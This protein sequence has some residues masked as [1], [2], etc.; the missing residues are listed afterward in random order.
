MCLETKPITAFPLIKGKPYSYCRMC[1][2]S[3]SK[4]YRLKTKEHKK[5]VDRI[6]RSKPEV[7]ERRKGLNRTWRKCNA[8][9]VKTRRRAAKL[10]RLYGITESDYRDIVARQG[11]GC[12]ICGN[13]EV[14]NGRRLA[15]D[16]DHGNGLVRGVLCGACNKGIGQLGDTPESVMRA[17]KYLTNNLS[18]EDQP[19]LG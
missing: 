14:K 19:W 8:E 10:I 6:Y 2:S 5:D 9:R 13:L 18:D 1:K 15:V 12:A 3:S 11:G 16:H 17:Y 7:A 4:A